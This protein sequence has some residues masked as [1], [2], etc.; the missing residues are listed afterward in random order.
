MRC[1]NFI[2]LLQVS[3]TSTCWQLNLC[4]STSFPLPPRFRFLPS[5]LHKC[6]ETDRYQL[7]NCWCANLCICCTSGQGP[8]QLAL[9]QLF[10]VHKTIQDFIVHYKLLL[11]LIKSWKSNMENMRIV[12]FCNSSY[13]T[14][15]HF[16]ESPLWSTT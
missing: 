1:I 7:F 3:F 4:P 10:S 16:V 5:F 8:I 9:L 6:P 15:N 12:T 11:N 13:T 2:S 14:N